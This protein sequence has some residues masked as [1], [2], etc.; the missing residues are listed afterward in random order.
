MQVTLDWNLLNQ[1]AS[2][3][4]S[5]F[6]I[7]LSLV[8]MLIAKTDA[9]RSE[10]LQATIQANI[11][12]FAGRISGLASVTQILERNSVIVFE[13]VIE[14]LLLRG[15]SHELVGRQFNSRPALLP[16]RNTKPEAHTPPPA[17]AVAPSPNE[18]A[19][20]RDA[21]DPLAS[22]VERASNPAIARKYIEIVRNAPGELLYSSV[23]ASDYAEYTQILDHLISND[24]L[25]VRQGKLYVPD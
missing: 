12:D 21:T 6:A 24:V 3:T 13:R 14:G 11:V 23:I 1:I 16:E 4:L 9:Q 19:N 15:P 25:V 10:K 8:A 7:I 5:I 18:A 17:I 2:F 20:L 22:A